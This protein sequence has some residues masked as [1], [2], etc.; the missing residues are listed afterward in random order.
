MKKRKGIM[1][2]IEEY[3]RQNNERLNM[4]KI[5]WIRKL[6]NKNKKRKMKRK[7][8]PWRFKEQIKRI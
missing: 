8:T 7:T 5:G 2:F 1:S 3:M 4:T 6:Q